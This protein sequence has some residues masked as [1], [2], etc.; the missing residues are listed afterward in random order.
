MKLTARALP[1]LLAKPDASV[2]AFLL[3]G[4]DQ[5]RVDAARADLAKAIAGPQGDD[6]M[7]ITRISAAE[8]RRDVAL[9]LDAMKAVSFFPGP[10]VAVVEGATDAQAATIVPALDDWAPGD[11]Q[12]I[13]TAGSL[14][15]KSALRKAFEG[16]K[17]AAAVAF[18]DDPLSP[19][20][21][22]EALRLAGAPV[23]P[24]ATMAAL[25][26]LAS[27]MDLTS[28]RGLA[29]KIAL[30]AMGDSAPMTPAELALI[31]VPTEAEVDETIAVV[32]EGNLG[33][34]AEALRK[35]T[36][37]GIGPVTLVLAATRHFR[38]LHR[39]KSDPAG[40]GAL[41]PPV[42][43][44]LRDQM[45]RQVRA[46]TV[47]ALEQAL[48]ILTETDLRLRSSSKAPDGAL[49]ERALLRITS[50]RR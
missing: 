42:F 46:W 13:V 44:P 27:G 6:E 26:D 34:A 30:Y 11:A 15:A 35:L 48:E 29:E 32:A 28:F 50:L 33:R 24:Q 38:G 8:L 47:P 5:I 31:A 49:V 36:V 14:T 43:G 16:H 45:T 7:R 10:R 39:A 19:A 2:P 4:A 40:L 25:N 18:Y 22:E 23:L 17:S 3:F 1:G 37:Q 20:E 9:L 12:V 21:V 41:R